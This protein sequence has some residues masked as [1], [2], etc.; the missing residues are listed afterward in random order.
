M[1]GRLRKTRNQAPQD[2]DDRQPERDSEEDSLP[3][4][5][6]VERTA[7]DRGPLF[8]PAWR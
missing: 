2:H 4:G 1:D 5:S 8:P 6:P 3:A 7:R